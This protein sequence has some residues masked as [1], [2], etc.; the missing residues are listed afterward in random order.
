MHDADMNNKNYPISLQIPVLEC[1]NAQLLTDSADEKYEVP[2]PDFAERPRAAH[3]SSSSMEI[4]IPRVKSEPL[5]DDVLPPGSRCQSTAV[6]YTVGTQT[7]APPEA[8][9]RTT[10]FSIVIPRI[11]DA[12]SAVFPRTGDVYPS[13][14]LTPAQKKFACDESQIISAT[15]NSP[16][17]A[18]SLNNV[19]NRRISRSYLIYA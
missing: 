7:V 16:S 10:P 17:D 15:H 14:L 6:D 12:P 18:L 2:S 13:K 1:E 5:E 9:L 4:P 19:R 3:F 8:H 11:W